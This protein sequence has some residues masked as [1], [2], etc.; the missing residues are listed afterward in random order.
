MAYLVDTSILMR[1]ANTTDPSHAVA[2]QAVLTLHRRGE[3][4]RTA[5]QNLVEFWNAA[6]RPT[7]ANGLGLAPPDAELKVA[8]FESTYPILPETPDIF[9]AWKTLVRAAGVV[10]KQT[11]DARLVAVC[12][13]Y[14]VTHILTFNV[15]HFT[16]LAAF[17]PGIAVVHP[18]SV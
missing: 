15:S 12:Q 1:L 5:P 8:S 17:C 14:G 10:G 11:H 6:T 3:E 2:A 4:L 7:T 13:V 16:R 9:P 18:G